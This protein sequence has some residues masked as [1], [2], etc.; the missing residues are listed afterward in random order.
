V[1]YG[2]GCGGVIHLMLER[3]RTARPLLARIA[4]AF[5]SR[6]PLAV[7]TLLEGPWIGAR[8]CWPATSG[9]EDVPG[10]EL[11]ERLTRLARRGFE[12]RRSFA[13]TAVLPEDGSARVRVEWMD[14][15]PGLFVFGAGDDAVPL[16]RLARQLGWY[17]AVADGRSNLATS[18]RFPE[19]DEVQVLETG[20]PLLP[21]CRRTDAAVVMTHSLE[22]DTRI[23]GVLL[24]EDLSY[25]GVLGPMQRTREM[26]AA[27]SEEF[28]PNHVEGRVENLLARLSAPMGLDLGG[29]TPADI[30]LAVMAE[31]QRSRY[32]ASGQP[33]KSVRGGAGRDLPAALR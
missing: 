26:L 16:V 27:L 12:E 22:Q 10:E 5:A 7:A 18:A 4:E 25:I 15:R 19:A 17:V 23:L 8:G 33:L 6:G 1:P 31:I 11:R 2:M 20:E 30:A 13:Q 28:D 14:A 3:S 32:G 29:E 24:E 21:D 9:F